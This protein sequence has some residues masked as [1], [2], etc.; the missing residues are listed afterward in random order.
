MSLFTYWPCLAVQELWAFL[1]DGVDKLKD[2]ILDERPPL[3]DADCDTII[4]Q[5]RIQGTDAEDGAVLEGAGDEGDGGHEWHEER[6]AAMLQLEEEEELEEAGLLKVGKNVRHVLQD[7]SRTQLE[8]Y[9]KAHNEPK[10]GVGESGLP[11]LSMDVCYSHYAHARAQAH[12]HTH[13]HTHTLSLSLSHTHTQTCGSRPAR[14]GPGVC[15][16]VCVCV[17]HARE[18][19]SIVSRTWPDLL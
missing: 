9:L 1:S 6:E 13:T 14:M 3:T 7:A 18:R 16:C 4:E 19:E 11:R 2:P 17:I 15:V 5:G 12:T 8:R 10:N